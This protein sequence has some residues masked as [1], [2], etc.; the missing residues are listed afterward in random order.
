MNKYDF[1]LST[2]VSFYQR[3]YNVIESPRINKRDNIKL[4]S[5]TK[6]KIKNE[7]FTTQCGMVHNLITTNGTIQNTKEMGQK[8]NICFETS[9]TMTFTNI[10][11]LEL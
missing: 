10:Y 4:L 7:L 2:N 5:F 8:I 1:Q 9:L 3:T 11:G 6:I